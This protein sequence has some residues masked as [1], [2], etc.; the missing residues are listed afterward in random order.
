MVSAAD[1]ARNDKP[2]EVEIN[3]MT[4]LSG[5]GQSGVLNV[6]SLRVIE[7]TAA[8]QVINDA[9]P[10]QFDPAVGFDASSNAQGTVVFLLTGQTAATTT[11]HFHVYFDTSGSFTPLPVTPQVTLT[12]NVLDEDFASYRVVT[13]NASYFYHKQ[14]GG[15]SSLVDVNDIDWISWNSHR[16]PAGD[17]RGIP[18]LVHGDDGG[19][20]HP[21]R[22]TSSSTILNQ[23]PLKATFKST[24]NDGLW[25]VQ[26]EIFPTYARMTVLKMN[27]NYWFQYEGVPGGTLQG[28]LDFMVRA[29]GMQNLASESWTGDLGDLHGDE[30]VFMA[31]PNANRAIFL[32]HHTEDL[33]VDSYRPSNGEKMTIFGFGRDNNNRYLRQ[34]PKQFTIGLVDATTLDSVAPVVRNA[35]KPLDMALGA[36]EQQNGLNRT[37]LPLVF[38]GG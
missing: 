5:L 9:V 21:G 15:F 31:D 29:D 8:G 34:V 17:L 19:Y 38:E 22:T 24:S 33:I 10:F 12:D 14:G 1:Y 23:G 27:S 25:E 36:A 7:V 2:A 16:G 35:Y 37:Y 28:D 32:A 26:W 20:F 11:R 6:A 30:W 4:L 18:N 3:F 13:G